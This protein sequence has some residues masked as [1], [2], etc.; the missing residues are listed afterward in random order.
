MADCSMKTMQ[1]DTL[2]EMSFRRI[3]LVPWDTMISYTWKAVPL[4]AN[5]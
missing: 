4:R 2:V 3:V 1:I 5:G